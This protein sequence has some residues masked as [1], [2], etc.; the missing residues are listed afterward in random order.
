MFLY[1][2]DRFTRKEDTWTKTRSSLLRLM[3]RSFTEAQLRAI[4]RLKEG[5]A[6]SPRERKGMSQ[7]DMAY[8][9]LRRAGKPLHV[10]E[11]IDRIES[12]HHQQLD[13]E[14]LVS[15]L[16]KKGAAT[17]SLHPHRQERLRL[18]E[19]RAVAMLL[20]NYRSLLDQGWQP[21]FAAPFARAGHRACLG[22]A[23]G[24]GGAHHCQHGDR[25]GARPARTGV[26]TIRSTR[27]APGRARRCSS[28]WSTTIWSV[29]KPPLVGV[30]DDTGLARTGKKIPGASWQRDPLS[31]PFHVNLRWG[32]R[33]IQMG[34][35]FPHHPPGDDGARSLPIRFEEA[36]VVRKPGKRASG[37]GAA[38]L[39]GAK[40]EAQPL[41][42]SG[43]VAG[44]AA[45]AVG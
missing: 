41:D 30:L 5:K 9:I 6:E 17:G 14:S 21:V 28:R 20:T 3:I 36:P 22:L 23:V 37:T 39:S 10:S 11:I 12:V 35:L 43:E 34:L 25:A 38:N 45:S 44:P 31:P 15:A 27:A 18:V 19:R 33:F 40:E 24:A 13:R 29:T 4:R 32:Q 2:L 26:P 16:V 7:V 8:D 42:S 1:P